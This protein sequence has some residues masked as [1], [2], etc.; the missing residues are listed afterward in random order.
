M[1]L[2]TYTRPDG[3]V[4]VLWTAP[5]SRHDLDTIKARD[6]PAD[7]TDVQ[8]ITPD[9][10]PTDRALRNAWRR[11]GNRIVEDLARARE[12]A[13]EAGMANSSAATLDAIRTYIRGRS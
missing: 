13:A 4:E 8:E 3:S 11:S 7:A 1:P 5:H 9:Q 10:L 2:V 6:I 12:L